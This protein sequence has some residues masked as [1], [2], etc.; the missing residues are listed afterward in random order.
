M[1]GPS[2]HSHRKLKEQIVFNHILV[3]VDGSTAGAQAL[4]LADRI[5]DDVRLSVVVPRP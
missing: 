3:A 4:A 5:A 1:A 2:A